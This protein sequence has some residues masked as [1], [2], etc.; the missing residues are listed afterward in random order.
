MLAKKREQ[1]YVFN[2]IKYLDT[3]TFI[4]K[5]KIN[6]VKLQATVLV[7]FQSG[8]GYLKYTKCMQHRS[9]RPIFNFDPCHINIKR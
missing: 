8:C 6:R 1:I 4:V 7:P 5:L 9:Q 3:S 2:G